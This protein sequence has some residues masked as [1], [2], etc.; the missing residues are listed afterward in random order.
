ME[1]LTP[2]QVE[3][4]KAI[5]QEYTENAEAVGSE[6][7]EKKYKLGV[8]PA[9]IRNEM[10]ELTKKG[11]LKKTHFSSGREPSAKGFRLYI[12]HLMKAKELS[13]TDEVAFKNSVWDERTEA[14]RLLQQATKTLA[15]KTDLLSLSA[16]NFGDLYY[17][18]VGN[19]LSK[20]EFLDLGLS[21]NLFL[22]LDE[23]D[24]WERVLDKFYRLDEDILYLLGEEDFRDP[25]LESCG[26]IF[27]E[28]E[29]K[30]IKGIIGVLGPKRMYYEEISP[31]IR[32]ISQ[33]IGD[34]VK[35]QGL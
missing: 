19:L 30:K 20:P 11:Y 34:I 25:I 5:I 16:T 13:T 22:L 35:A 17:A 14:H 7:L 12:K 18:G 33:L 27:G 32:Y 1:D 4:L 3:I 29:G 6:I 21:K 28:F 9:T 24:Y 23:V 31:Q 2:R 10:V 8:S 15:D 26:C